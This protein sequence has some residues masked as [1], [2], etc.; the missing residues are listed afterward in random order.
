MVPMR[1][2]CFELDSRRGRRGATRLNAE[3]LQL[4]LSRLS[5]DFR[6]QPKAV[7]MRT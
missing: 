2:D 3:L 4:R 1:S 6:Q 7:L 5:H